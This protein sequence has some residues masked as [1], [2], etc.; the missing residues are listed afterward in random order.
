MDP[1]S[2]I[3]T[4]C[5]N[6]AVLPNALRSVETALDFLR[7][8]AG[9]Q[10]QVLGEVVVVDDGSTDG[11]E[12]FLGEWMRG[13]DFY[14]LVRRPR[15]SSPACAR[16]AGVVAARGELL[17]FLD[18]DDLYLPEHLDDCLRELADPTLGFVKTGV[19]LADPVHPDWKQRIE[20]SVVINLCVR[21]RCH[22]TIGG[23]PDYHLCVRDGDGLRAELDLFWK[24]EDQFYMELLTRLFRGVRVVRE[25]VR[26]LRYPGNSFDRQYEKFR[27]PFG[28]YPEVLPP[29]DRFRL[30]LCEQICRRR[31]EA[32]RA[33]AATMKERRAETSGGGV[34][35]GR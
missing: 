16:N 18:A 6:A 27:R 19:A 34:G 33:T 4:T 12:P 13:K 31:L 22:E 26:H 2:V 1:F 3:V 20:H 15:S 14:T 23:F 21:R 17:F 7:Q 10:R 28:A 11:T 29:E 5:N 32:L 30:A 9:R 35:I 25:T 24:Y 8:S